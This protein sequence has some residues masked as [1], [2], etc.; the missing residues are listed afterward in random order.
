MVITTNNEIY[1][2]NEYW[3]YGINT[4]AVA[5]KWITG[6]VVNADYDSVNDFLINEIGLINSALDAKSVGDMTVLVLIK[7]DINDYR[8]LSVNEI[9]SYQRIKDVA[10]AISTGIVK[11]F[12]Y[13]RVLESNESLDLDS[14]AHYNIL[15]HLKMDIKHMHDISLPT[16]NVYRYMLGQAGRYS[17]IIK[18]I[19][20]AVVVEGNNADHMPSSVSETVM[21]FNASGTITSYASVPL[22]RI[23]SYMTGNVLTYSQEELRVFVETELS[24]MFDALQAQKSGIT[25]IFAKSHSAGEH[26]TVAPVEYILSKERLQPIVSVIDETVLSFIRLNSER[27]NGFLMSDSDK[28][29]LN[30]LKL[31]HFDVADIFLKNGQSGAVWNYILSLSDNNTDDLKKTIQEYVSTLKSD[32]SAGTSE[33][34]SSLDILIKEAQR[35]SVSGDNGEYSQIANTICDIVDSATKH[36]HYIHSVIPVNAYSDINVLRDAVLSALRSV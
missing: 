20:D 36:L 24:N 15:T 28:E 6:E 25:S 14:L 8:L 27:E 16:S 30:T 18:Q 34:A 5:A 10:D 7:G 9:L 17:H 1:R 3:H 19:I 26:T 29:Y 31:L 33:Q 22:D 12:E 4:I 2:I 11:C 23:A 13:E 32:N 21:D 35:Y